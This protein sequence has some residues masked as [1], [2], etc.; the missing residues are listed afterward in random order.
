MSGINLT[1]LPK[2]TVS[3][4]TNSQADRTVTVERALEDQSGRTAKRV[5]LLLNVTL[6][7]QQTDRLLALG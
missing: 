5:M 1:Q 7:P 3:E 6:Q 2:G 4:D